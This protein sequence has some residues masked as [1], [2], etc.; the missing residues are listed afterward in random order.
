MDLGDKAP[1]YA[2]EIHAVSGNMVER[3]SSSCGSEVSNFPFPP[4]GIL[5]PVACYARV[6]SFSREIRRLQPENRF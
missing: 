3:S 1:R 6:E 4:L 5:H 2:N